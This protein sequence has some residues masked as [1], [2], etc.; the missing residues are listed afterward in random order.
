V[1]YETPPGTALNQRLGGLAA[2]A[3]RHGDVLF[4]QP[5]LAAPHS[6]DAL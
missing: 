3:V 2:S 4:P 6:L 1:G 5:G